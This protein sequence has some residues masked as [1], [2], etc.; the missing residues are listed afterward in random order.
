MTLNT[1]KTVGEIAAEYPAAARVFE[2][3]HID[4]CCG[5]NTQLWR[6]AAWPASG[7]R[8]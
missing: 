3:H 6:L 5:E 7:P 4:Y 8:T 1:E 2:K